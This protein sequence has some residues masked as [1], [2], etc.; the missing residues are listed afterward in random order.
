MS[1]IVVE[2][3]PPSVID[4]EAGL[5]GNPG[6]P[7][8][9][10]SQGPPGTTGPAGPP[11]SA[12]AQGVEGPVGPA[13]PAGAP[14]A[15]GDQGPGAQTYAYVYQ[16]AGAPPPSS[17]RVRANSDTAT[18]VTTVWVSRFTTG[19]SDVR[20]GLMLVEE[21]GLLY[22]QD[23]NDADVYSRFTTTA[24]PID[25][26]SYVEFAVEY[27][28]HRG[29]VTNNTT[30]RLVVAIAGIAG[31]AGPPGATGPTGPQGATGPTGAQG[32]AGA[33]GAAGATGSQGPK[34]DKGDTGAAGPTGS[35]GPTG[36][37]GATGPAGQWTQIT[38]AAYNALSP[39]DP[40][41][42]YVVVG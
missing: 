17:G 11:G 6:P 42:L 13:G 1:E 4:V 41:V 7:G 8:P 37:A 12:G 38:Q 20:N 40:A 24:D 25:Q 10:G 31:P 28:D 9:P 16:S 30:L 22:F 3:T 33:P 27:V 26:G 18:S 14:G 21:G 5:G 34:G 19:G 35:Q 23:D 32:P 15:K 39:P 2:I 29:S 36:P